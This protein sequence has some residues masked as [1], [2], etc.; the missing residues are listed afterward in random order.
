MRIDKFLWAVRIYKTRT[1]A[2]D[3]C[4]NGRITIS[5]YNVKPSREVNVGDVFSVR[6]T[7]IVRTFRIKDMLHNRVGAKLVINY[8]DDITPPEEL[9]KLEDMIEHNKNQRDTGAGRPTKK[10][11]REIDK[12]LW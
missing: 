4:K 3:A 11:R 2:T 6:I 1:Q 9:Q 7:P 5:N 8:I 10:E 12:L